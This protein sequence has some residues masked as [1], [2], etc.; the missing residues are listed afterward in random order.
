MTSAI[1]HEHLESILDKL[2]G[3]DGVFFSD[4]FELN[5]NCEE[6]KSSVRAPFQN[7]TMLKSLPKPYR[8][9]TIHRNSNELD[10]C[11]ASHISFFI[12]SDVTSIIKFLLA[13]FYR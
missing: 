2:I 5:K 13:K 9:S 10:I 11:I 12:L 3:S 1:E 4:D 6:E 7:M 8:I